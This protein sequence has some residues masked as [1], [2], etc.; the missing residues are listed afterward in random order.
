MQQYRKKPVVIEAVQFDGTREL[1]EAISVWSACAVDIVAPNDYSAL[2]VTTLEGT[3]TASIGDYIIKGL[4]GE[5]YPCKPDIFER[6]YDVATTTGLTFGQAIE[7]LKA[8]KLVARL[9]WNGKGMWLSYTAGKELAVMDL[10]SKATRTKLEAQGVVTVPING[11]ISMYTA[12]GELQPGWLAS[13][14]DMLAEDW[15]ILD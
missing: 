9:G 1:A 4:K 8:G 10:W 11:Y 13:Q 12:T 5:F 14:T 7:A 3:M 6:S 15:C 2:V